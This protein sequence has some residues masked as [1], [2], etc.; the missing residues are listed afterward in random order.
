MSQFKKYLEIVTEGKDYFYNEEETATIEDNV[1]AIKE[2]LPEIKPGG[3]D[4]SMHEKINM[5]LG[6]IIDS[7]KMLK[8]SLKKGYKLQEKYKDNFNYL[9]ILKSFIESEFTG[10]L[11]PTTN[12]SISMIE[13]L[14]KDIEK[15]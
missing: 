8:N 14:I 3:T 13:K 11:I 12:D 7:L 15:Y 10:K 2:I 1:I 6:G 5:H 9:T 4:L